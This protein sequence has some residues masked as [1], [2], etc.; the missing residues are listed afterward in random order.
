VAAKNLWRE[1]GRR[2]IR[3]DRLIFAE[4]VADK[5]QH[6]R[7][8]SLADLALDTRIYNGHTTTCDALWAGVPVVTLEGRHFASRV[9]ASCLKAVGLDEMVTHSLAE[10]EALAIR[11]AG[12]PAER[13]RIRERLAAN[14]VA[15]PLFDTALFTRHLEKAFESMWRRFEDGLPPASF[16]VAP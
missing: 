2:G 6:L 13:R 7:R 5:A 12:D 11:L 3:P 8:M 16:A 1:A 14:R 15:L 4:R 9:S 10:Y